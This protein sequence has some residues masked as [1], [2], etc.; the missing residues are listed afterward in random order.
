MFEASIATVMMA[1]ITTNL[2]LI[3]LAI[4]LI[5]KKLLLQS[6]YRLL[7]IFVVFTAL[8][9]ALP[10][11]FP[12]TINP[13]LPSGISRFILEIHERRFS[14][15]GQSFSLWNL[16]TWIWAIG[17]V[18]GIARYIV[19]YLQSNYYII[20]YGKELTHRPV[21]RDKLEQ[22]CKTRNRSNHFRVIE[23]PGLDSPMLF[24]IFAPRILVPENMELTEPNLSY[25]LRHE[26]SHHF[27]H[28]L[29][30]KSI[31]QIITLIYWWN[32]FCRL[33][34]SQVDVILEMRIDDGIALTDVMSTDEYMRCLVHATTAISKRAPLS[35]SLTIG[36]FS[37]RNAALKRRFALLTNNQKKSRPAMNVLLL[38][39]T[40]TI[41][42]ASYAIIPE[43]YCTIDDVFPEQV[44]DEYKIAPSSQN[45]IYFIDNGDGS[46]DVYYKNKYTETIDS[47][48]YYPSDTPVYTKENCPV[49][50]F[51]PESTDN[52]TAGDTSGDTFADSPRE[53]TLLMVGDIL[54][55][56]PVEESAL[57]P[58]GSYQFDTLFTHTREAIQSADLALVN[59]EVILGGAELGVSGYPAFNAPFEAGDALVD[60][61]F[62][63]IC[64]GTNH[65][66][67]KGKKGLLNCISYW[68]EIHPGIRVLGIYDSAK[69]QSDI[70]IYEQND[71]SVAILNYT[72]GTN[73]IPLPE[74]MPYAVNILDKEKVTADIKLA[75]EL[76]DFTVVCPHWGTE[77]RLTSDSMQEE[78][79]KLFLENG[80]DLVLGTHPHVIEPI[81]WVRD[82]ASGHEMLVYYSLG[83]YVNWTSGTGEGVA[84]RMVGGMAEITL[85]ADKNDDIVISD[86]GVQ[87]LVCHV[88][89]GVNGVTVYPLSEYSEELSERNAIASQDGSFSKAYCVRLCDE[90]WGERWE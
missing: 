74:D 14:F 4:C 54:L 11:D 17:T 50:S 35:Q 79:T 8:R 30:L 52:T 47:L 84:N 27:H 31:I 90:V 66:L 32:P 37:N 75:E 72:Y 63:V 18:I 38:L 88:E 25:I 13:R 56:T 65:A 57:Q 53:L 26:T 44:L 9:L 49:P 16:F 10:F 40:V 58:D 77:Y 12:F 64:H 80:V 61:G 68:R 87:A 24:G 36:L 41:Y 6:G 45:N 33:L 20:L 34:N 1:V 7:S 89:H 55:H 78:W 51:S 42:L 15:Y 59:Q 2:F 67:D 81:E 19:S 60:A 46:Y 5:N 23:L 21:Y 62:D 48:E 85:S 73:G 39:A 28:D 29:A 70:Y 22:I 86:Y 82:E 71:I 76:A 69:S 83:N 3:L 43:A